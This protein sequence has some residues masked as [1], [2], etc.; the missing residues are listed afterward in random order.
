LEPD[1]VTGVNKYKMRAKEFLTEKQTLVKDQQAAIPSMSSVGVPELPMGPTNY[2]H[3]Y[4]LGVHMAGSPDNQFDYPT[5]G[6]F[7]DDMVMI[8]YSSADKEII[9]NSVK[10]FGYDLKKHTPDGSREPKDTNTASPVANW[11]K[12]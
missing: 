12:K 2:Y 6:Q 4:R 1:K 8:G 5:N 7:V 11:M 3:K 10:A 9:A